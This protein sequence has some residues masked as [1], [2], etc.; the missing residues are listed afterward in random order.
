MSKRTA[1]QI[2]RSQLPELFNTLIQI[3]EDIFVG[4][5]IGELKRIVTSGI[6]HDVIPVE[7]W[8]I[9]FE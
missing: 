5:N 4:K 9:V 1:R 2:A 8:V 6:V 7:T 3:N